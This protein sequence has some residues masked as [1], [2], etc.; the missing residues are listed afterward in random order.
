[1]NSG[2]LGLGLVGA[3]GFG[4]FC[5]E[6]YRSLPG[7]RL[8]AVCDID[9]ARAQ[10]V[11]AEFGL[12]AYSDYAAMLADPAVNIVAVNTPPSSH[13]AQTIQ[14]ARAGQHIFCEKPLATTL[15]DAEAALRAAHEAAVVLGVDYVMRPNPLYRLLRRITDLPGEHGAI[16]GPLRRCALENFAADENL[17]PDHW[18]WD[19]AVSG[20]IFVEHGVH[21]FDLFNWQT[22]ANPH[23]VA[24]L[25]TPRNPALTD[26]VQALVEYEGG[27]TAS[28]YHTFTRANAAEHQGL[29]FGW[30]WAT[31]EVH[32]WIALDLA[33]EGLLDAAGLDALAA[34]L[35]ED[36]ATLLAVGGEP[37]DPAAALHWQVV[38]AWPEG[39]PMRGHG[40]TRRLVARVRLAATLGG[41]PAKSAVYAAGVRAGMADLLA[42]IA[43][44]RPPAV[45]PA[46]LWTSTAVGLAAREAAHT[47]S[48]VPVPPPPA[49]LTP[50]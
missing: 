42:S 47:G 29:T 36:P 19:E 9:P 26:T 5:L 10:A 48:T 41:P 14:A 15:A 38:E 31:A 34:L 12:T 11:A 22:G 24:A 43:G 17:G 18:F 37:P 49:W 27:A 28:A 50:P 30:D 4:R 35:D 40:A 23:R 3:G 46:D 33:L 25:T 45:S 2:T 7:L 32:G 8:V 44:T 21:F 1:M 16:F 6:A 39:R 13:A 20:G